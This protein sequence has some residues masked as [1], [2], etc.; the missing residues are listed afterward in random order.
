MKYAKILLACDYVRILGIVGI[1]GLPAQRFRCGIGG[2]AP[3]A[4]PPD[5]PGSTGHT[6]IIQNAEAEKTKCFTSSG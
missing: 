1:R 3:L 5:L 4:S 2:S 6:E